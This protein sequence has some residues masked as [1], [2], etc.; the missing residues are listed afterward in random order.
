[1][2]FDVRITLP[3]TP[4]YNLAEAISLVGFTASAR[5]PIPPETEWDILKNDLTNHLVS[6]GIVPEDR[7]QDLIFDFR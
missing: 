1:M 2:N 3:E 6:E 7:R 4:D 5:A